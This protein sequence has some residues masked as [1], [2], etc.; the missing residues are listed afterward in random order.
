MTNKNEKT[1]M[2]IEVF[3]SINNKLDDLINTLSA[4]DDAEINTGIRNLKETG[5]KIAGY[6]YKYKQQT[7]DKHD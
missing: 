7:S 1:H 3:T 4:Y 2:S 5:V 6:F